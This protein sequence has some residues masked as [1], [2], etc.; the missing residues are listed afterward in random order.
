MPNSTE[1]FVIGLPDRP[2]KDFKLWCI[3]FSKAQCE[4]LLITTETVRNEYGMA[5]SY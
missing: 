5:I 4:Y 2:I 1:A 3:N